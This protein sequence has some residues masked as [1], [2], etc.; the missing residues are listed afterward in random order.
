MF[1]T[2]LFDNKKYHDIRVSFIFRNRIYINKIYTFHFI[3][4]SRSP[5]LF[6][7]E[8]HRLKLRLKTRTSTQRE[9]GSEYLE[10][11][12]ILQKPQLFR[13]FYTFY[14]LLSG[15]TSSLTTH[16][17]IHPLCFF[18]FFFFEK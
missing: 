14:F 17:P 5:T 6:Y 10:W 2:L 7:V 13:F 3:L 8:I 16:I 18:F 15:C 4:L 9:R 1:L 11:V 12:I